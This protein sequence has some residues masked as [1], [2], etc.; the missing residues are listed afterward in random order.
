MPE[1]D[2]TLPASLTFK[3]EA[4]TAEK[5]EWALRHAFDS[6]HPADPMA[7]LLVPVPHV[8][9][10]R[11]MVCTFDAADRESVIVEHV[12]QVVPPKPAVP[13]ALAALKLAESF[14]AGFEGDELQ[15]GIS[16]ML[17]E[18]RGAIA[19]SESPTSA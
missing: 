13:R 17:A 5:A 4:A 8:E 12:G 16:D 2:V 1:F 3:V 18:I 9:S 10:A 7:G 19:Q 6:R 14:I 15:D 11:V